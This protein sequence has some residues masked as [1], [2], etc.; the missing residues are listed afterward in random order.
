MLPIPIRPLRKPGT[1]IRAR[2]SNEVP[3]GVA[4]LAQ[5][6]VDEE[7]AEA[8]WDLEF[9]ADD[10]MDPFAVLERMSASLIEDELVG[11]LLQANNSTDT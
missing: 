9:Q 6:I 3:K 11:D 10:D 1:K 7:D 4:A 8:A 2:R 5:K